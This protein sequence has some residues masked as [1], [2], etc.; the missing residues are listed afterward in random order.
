L[1]KRK[2][3]HPKRN[4]INSRNKTPKIIDISDNSANF[5][6]SVAFADFEGPWGWERITVKLL[7][8]EVIPKL[9]NFATM[10]WSCLDSGKCHFI[11]CNQL[12]QKAKV[13]LKELDKEDVQELF[14]LRLDS[15]K[16][17]FG[18][19]QGQYFHILW[20]APKHEVCPSKKKRA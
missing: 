9:Q 8:N 1:S 3:K 10:K 16:R 2:S 20:W 13:R 6:W 15:K 7:F 12:S 19:R 18:Q 17:I 4:E 5:K 14:S 11:S